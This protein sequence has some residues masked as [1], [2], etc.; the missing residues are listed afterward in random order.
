MNRLTLACFSVVGL[1]GLLGTA[2]AAT[3]NTTMPVTPANSAAADLPYTIAKLQGQ[4]GMLQT[5][6]Q[7]L[8]QG[9]DAT[10]PQYVFSTAPAPN[11][12]GSP[13]PSGG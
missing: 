11:A 3:L 1:C 5:E 4:V 13:I 8:Q 7:N 10:G 12:D 9:Q 2:N 6:I